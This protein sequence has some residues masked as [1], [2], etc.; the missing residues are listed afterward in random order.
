[1]WALSVPLRSWEFRETLTAFLMGKLA[2]VL[3]FSVRQLIYFNFHLLNEARSGLSEPEH[4]TNALLEYGMWCLQIFFLCGKFCSSR[5]WGV[6]VPSRNPI[7]R[8]GSWWSD[9]ALKLKI[10]VQTQEILFLLPRAS[11]KWWA[12]LSWLRMT[13][14]GN[15]WRTATLHQ[16]HRKRLWY[17]RL[18]SLY[19]ISLVFISI[20]IHF[21]QYFRWAVL[22]YFH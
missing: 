21:I 14:S 10:K 6:S 9:I 22:L 17:S 5:V 8:V 20:S 1:M 3:T 18:L 19:F 15:I 13:T 4:L 12:S 16:R 11:C 7:W 2:L